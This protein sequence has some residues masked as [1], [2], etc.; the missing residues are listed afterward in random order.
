VIARLGR[1]GCMPVPMSPDRVYE[2]LAEGTRTGKLA[3]VR[4][5]GRP[6]VAPVWFILDGDDLIFTTHE[7]TVK[8]RTL[9]RDPR[10]AL[11]VDLEEPPYAFAMVE[12]KVAIETDPVIALPYSIAI[13]RRYMGAHLADDYGRRNA[14]RGEYLVRLTP[15]RLTGMD[16]M[17]GH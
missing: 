3:T 14:V 2:F 5:D 1:L 6:H 16:D 9:R 7:T 12:G 10:A 15:T 4:A 11:T 13:A 8:G 17:A